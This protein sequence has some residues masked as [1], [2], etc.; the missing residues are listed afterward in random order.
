[1]TISMDM[2]WDKIY[3][4]WLGKCIGC[5][6]GKPIEGWDHEEILSRLKRIG[7]YPL[8]YYIPMEF[9]TEEELVERRGLV[10]GEIRCVERDDDVDY[11]ILNL[12]VVEKKGYNF[13]TEDVADAWLSKIPYHCIYTAERV[14]YR[15]LVM[16]LKPPLTAR[17]FNPYKEWIGARIRADVWGWLCPADPTKAVELARRDAILSHTGE[18]VYGAMFQAAL[19]ANAFKVSN[20]LELIDTSIEYVP[21]ESRLREV[22]KFIKE[23]RSRGVTWEIAI[24]E[25]LKR[26]SNY[27]RVHVI[28][29]TA[30]ELIALMWSEE[31][32][33]KG[34]TLAVMGGLDTDCNGAN[35]G[36]ILGV[37]SGASGI[38]KEWYEVFNDKVKTAVCGYGTLSIKE[39]AKR[40]LN[41]VTRHGVS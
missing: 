4:G 2:L 34:I 15:N 24:K 20:V 5:M 30:I 7:E 21:E 9:F 23:L 13:T 29:N 6:L 33:S 28:N 11:M 14:A 22:T 12:E 32:F 35:V 25:V 26:Y 10:R 16:G 37:M 1:M 36:A 8:K 17:F 41:L 38:P 40:C 19:V 27:P 18:G 31:D 39:L 3:G